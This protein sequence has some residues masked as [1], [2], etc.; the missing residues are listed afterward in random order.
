MKMNDPVVA[1]LRFVA[2]SDERSCDIWTQITDKSPRTVTE[3]IE[4]M[5]LSPYACKSTDY[6]GQK[7]IRASVRYPHGLPE[8]S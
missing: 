6:K 4:N 3:E 2:D 7:G 8:G 1:H 5:T